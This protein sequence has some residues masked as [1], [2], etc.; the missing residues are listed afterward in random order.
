MNQ[1][2][3]ITLLSVT[4]TVAVAVLF[5]LG[6][7]RP[8][9][10]AGA[11]WYVH[12]SATGANNGTG[13][14]DA[15]TDLQ[16]ALAAAIAGDQIWVAT[17]TYKPAAPGNQTAS[18]TLKSGVAIYGGFAGGET[19]LEQRDW[20]AHVAILNGDLSGD[21]GLDFSNNGENSYHVVIGATG[22]TLDGFTVT[23]GNASDT[24]AQGGGISNSGVSPVLRNLVI[25]GNSANN[26]G[27]GIYS[28][29][30]SPS[31]S[32]ITVSGNRAQHG[33]GLLFENG[34]IAS[35]TNSTISDNSADYGGGM[36]SLGSTPSLSNSTFISNSATID[37][38]G[39][40]L[41]Q[42]SATIENLTV[43]GNSAAN[44]GGGIC[45]RSSNPTL[46]NVVVSGNAAGMGGGLSN[47][48][49][50]QVLTNVT[51]SGN[52][53][54][55][56]YSQLGV[57]V[58]RNTIVWGNTGGTI[59]SSGTVLAITYSI[60]EGSYNNPGNLDANPLFVAAVPVAPST[61]GNLRLREASPAIDAG[62]NTIASPSLP[63]ADRDGQPRRF[64]VAAVPD[65]G[66]GDAPV[67]D[68]GAYESQSAAVNQQP[69]LDQPVALTLLEDAGE[70]VV[71]LGGI[72]TGDTSQTISISALSL[73]P[74]LFP[75]PTVSYT[76]ANVTGTLRFTPT[77]DANGSAAISV[78]VR[79]NG[80]TIGGGTDTLTRTF[81]VQITPVNDAPDFTAGPDQT[82]DSQAGPQTRAAWATGFSPGPANESGQA[83]QTY[84]VVSNT[85]PTLF[86]T[87]P[88]V[89]QN[90]AL[91]YTP[92]AGA[93]GAAT[94]GV[95]VSDNGGTANG[96]VNTSAV[97]TFT[98]TV[99]RGITPPPYHS[100]YL[101]L[102]ARG[103]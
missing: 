18:F 77:A 84:N 35:L 76:G 21:D 86:A 92:K 38:G 31:I 102:V 82:V 52:S 63:A 91:T 57:L 100:V 36:Y 87:A 11:I 22:A 6:A 34:S 62:D 27:G 65:T 47:H 94:I 49:S 70:Q 17:G 72:G 51:I 23:G 58:I 5:A 48:D 96:G 26:G 88:A 44:E 29:G 54:G 103:T 60:V 45:D 15:Y 56:V 99:T 67:V 59:G 42:S 39:I 83:L 75:N 66:N 78:V 32:A 89:D 24:A 12:A 90:G 30:G 1:R 8:A 95:V 98:I 14:A 81:A 20:H 79:D 2:S 13:W 101:P 16:S 46:T 37:G 61:G 10:A 9:R 4:T 40:M 74:S 73:N 33:G 85:S 53:G 41:F 80:G 69:T 19:A 50:S 28:N 25:S 3:L 43:S 71:N 97:R 64:D 7:A 55:A 93:S 68:M